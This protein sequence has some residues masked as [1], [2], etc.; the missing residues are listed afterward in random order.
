MN[1]LSRMKRES[2]MRCAFF[3]MP[4]IL[5][6]R[7]EY[8]KMSVEAKLMYTLFLD[9]AR[10]SEKNNL[11]NQ[12]NEVY[13]FY[14]LEELEL[15][16][17]SAKKKVIKT[18]KELLDLGLIDEEKTGRCS[19]FYLYELNV[20]ETVIAE[21]ESVVAIN[22]V[23]AE[24][25]KQMTQPIQEIKHYDNEMFKKESDVSEQQLDLSNL[26]MPDVTL[27]AISDEKVTKYQKELDQSIVN[28][29]IEQTEE[30]TTQ[31]V[32]LREEKSDVSK[33]QR[34]FSS[35]INQRFQ[36]KKQ[37]EKKVSCQNDTSE[38]LKGH[39]SNNNII[40]NNNIDYIDQGAY[41]VSHKKTELK[42]L[43]R[44]Q[45]LYD[46][47]QN[48]EFSQ[49]IAA[50]I[51]VLSAEEDVLLLQAALRKAEQ[52]IATGRL[53]YYPEARR[54]NEALKDLFAEQDYLQSP[55]LTHPVRFALSR[56][57]NFI[58]TSENKGKPVK[59]KHAYYTKAI[60]TAIVEYYHKHYDIPI[61]DRV[62]YYME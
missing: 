31:K 1:K 10:L 48:N 56:A 24:R 51:R 54:F 60:V 11:V 52:D 45:V 17:S 6:I 62:L 22:E 14:S 39:P 35:L 29:T 8:L 38:V 32:D 25:T 30:A 49:A 13:F 43:N 18:K 53:N 55:E 40:I 21:S 7:P 4:K 9:R 44:Q 3:I 23:K 46:V 59:N 36:T 27:S 26:F 5:F 16:L 61:N 57:F 28:S 20:E 41:D 19:R 34:A 37:I 58:Q 42:Q 33:R 2:F 50:T 12:D 15:M 47:I